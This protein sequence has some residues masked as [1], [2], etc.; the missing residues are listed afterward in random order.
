MLDGSS[1]HGHVGNG[2]SGVG[3]RTT[4]A[5]QPK[6][7]TDLMRVLG[8]YRQGQ[9]ARATVTI[10]PDLAT[11]MLAKNHPQN[12]VISGATLRKY[13][14][15]HEAGTFKYTPA[16]LI[17]S[18]AGFLGDGQ[19]RCSMVAQTGSPILADVVQ[20]FNDDDF[21]TARKVVDT[22]RTRTR[23][24]VLEIAG[25]VDPGKGALANGILS[26]IA[27]FHAGIDV[28][29]ANID[30][31]LTFRPWASAINKALALRSRWNMAMRAAAAVCFKHRSS[32]AEELFRQF[33]TNVDLKPG[34]A[35][36]ALVQMQPFFGTGRGRTHDE[37]VMLFIF[38]AAHAHMNGKILRQSSKSTYG[39]STRPSPRA[40]SYFFGSDLRPEQRERCR[41]I[42]EEE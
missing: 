31:V 30:Q 13:I 11:E 33:E 10:G 36:H 35:S 5:P 14:A 39:Y 7:L 17:I 37:E 3:K 16:P 6:T 2:T 21:E 23:G 40:L 32:S 18:G 1:G 42:K 8:Q 27:Y 25:M 20:M 38:K 4:E 19:H 34:M 24:H 41:A 12:R 29:R 28:S 26:R 15:Q 9:T 22:G